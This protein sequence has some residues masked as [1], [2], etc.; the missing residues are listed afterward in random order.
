MEGFDAEDLAVPLEFTA[1]G[2]N[3]SAIFDPEMQELLSKP[4]SYNAHHG[5]ILPDPFMED[6]AISDMY[7]ITSIN[8]DR[9]GRAFISSL[10][11][12]D[13]DTYPFWGVSLIYLICFA[14]LVNLQGLQLFTLPC[15][16]FKILSNVIFIS[17]S[18]I[19]K[20]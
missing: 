8:H 14:S 17:F 13:F 16:V 3:Q 4:I 15:V 20:K 2:A 7:A 6:P 19:P 9:N 11:A 1:Y 18:G 12:R 10:E 5:G